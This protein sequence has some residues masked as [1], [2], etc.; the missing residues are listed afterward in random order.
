MH[1]PSLSSPL[2]LNLFSLASPSTKG[3]KKKEEKTSH[4][5]RLSLYGAVFRPGV[6]SC[7]SCAREFWSLVSAVRQYNLG[8]TTTMLPHGVFL[9]VSVLFRSSTSW[10]KPCIVVVIGPAGRPLLHARWSTCL[11]TRSLSLITGDTVLAVL[12]QYLHGWQCDYIRKCEATFC[13]FACVV[14][15]WKQDCLFY[16]FWHNASQ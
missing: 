6:C 1:W 12:C 7:I 4:D 9:C 5:L 2:L 15:V 16:L 10:F 14:L 13:F 11:C 8:D 3:K